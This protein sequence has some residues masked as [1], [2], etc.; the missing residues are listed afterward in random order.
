MVPSREHGATVTFKLLKLS[1]DCV[2]PCSSRET[3]RN[4]Q[5]LGT[6]P[7]LPGSV[8]RRLGEADVWDSCWSPTTQLALVEAVTTVSKAAPPLRWWFTNLGHSYSA[9]FTFQL[10]YYI[11]NIFVHV[12]AKYLGESWVRC[13]GY[14]SSNSHRHKHVTINI[15]W[16]FLGP[17]FAC[18]CVGHQQDSTL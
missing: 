18:H 5:E 6:S 10:Y 8:A 7:C 14:V 3:C 2:S 11:D 4:E 1:G 16:N 12:W 9:T 13:A 15:N 17:L